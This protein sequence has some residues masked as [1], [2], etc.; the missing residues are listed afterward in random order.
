MLLY[1]KDG[2]LPKPDVVIHADT[3]AEM[4]ET[5][6][7]IH[8]WVI[9]FCEELGIDFRIV[10]SHRGTIYDDYFKAG[11]IPVIGFRSCTDN[12]KI[13]P[14]RREIRKIVGQGKRG[15]LLASSWLGIT[16]DE[17]SRRTSSDVKWCEITYPL[18]DIHRVTR[19]DCIDR[20]NLEGLNVIK[21]GCFHCP[22]AGSNFYRSLRSNHPD[23]FEKAI[24]LEANAEKRTLE[25]SGRKLR[26]GLVG[27]KKLRLL[28]SIQADN[29]TCDS[30]AG[31][32][33]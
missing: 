29:A 17:E 23:L 12:F 10:R 20:L 26:A 16:T 19:E 6:E 24:L 33:I 22:Y 18:L 11:A 32:F 5:V 30:G 14:Q 7:H 8:N 9:P 1:V 13:A 2:L 31:C 21:S 3:G 27:G 4:P 25:K 28:D 15:E